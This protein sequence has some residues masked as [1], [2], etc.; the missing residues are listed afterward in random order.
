MLDRSGEGFRLFRA[1]D[2]EAFVDDEGG[3]AGDADAVSLF[4]GGGDLV[5]V[6]IR[7]QEL[8]DEIGHHADFAGRHDQRL[9]VAEVGAFQEIE[10]E[11]PLG[12]LALQPVGARP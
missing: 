5:A 1:H 7:R 9:R 6:G 8:G 3:D 4:D 10:A 11:Q 2:D 12:H